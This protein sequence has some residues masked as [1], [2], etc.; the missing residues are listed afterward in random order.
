MNTILKNSLIS[1]GAAVVGI[2]GFYLYTQAA[3]T[4]SITVSITIPETLSI[5]DDNVDFSIA[6]LTP[7]VENTTNLNT[8]SVGSNSSTG[9]SVT[10]DLADLASVPGQLCGDSAA[11]AGTCDPSGNLF[12]GDGTA[13]YISITSDAGAGGLGSLATATFQPTETKLGN[14]SIEAFSAD[15]QT[16]TDTFDIHYNAYAD[17]TVAADIYKGTITFTISAKP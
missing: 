6:S 3:T 8:I 10:V 9:F 16:N 14:T 2:A 1:V 17:Y 7:E 13:S 11:P 15:D 4:D 5:A 12:D